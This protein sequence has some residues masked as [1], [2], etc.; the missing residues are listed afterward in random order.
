MSDLFPRDPG[1]ASHD[2]THRLG[3]SAARQRNL[4]REA[5]G[6]AAAVYHAGGGPLNPNAI[7]TTGDPVLIDYL[8]KLVTG[9]RVYVTDTLFE[10]GDGE[11]TGH[12]EHGYTQQVITL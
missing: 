7:P 2:K 12:F 1:Y 3:Q 10:G 11:V 6:L 8:R 5:E 9:A 4:A